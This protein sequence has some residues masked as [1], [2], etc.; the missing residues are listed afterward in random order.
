M[1]AGAWIV[2]ALIASTL[3]MAAVLLAR[4]PVRR[5]FGAQVAYALWALPALRLLL[6]P[7]P[8]GWWHAAAAAPITR[9]GETVVYLVEPFAG[10]PS[11]AGLPSASPPVGLMLG[12]AWVVG[13][14]LCLGW[15]AVRHRRFCR[16]VLA[17]ARPLAEHDGILIVASAAAP[18]PLAFGVRR[19][20]V[21]FPADFAERYDADERALALQ[22]ELGHHARRDLLANWAALAVLA[23]HWFSPLA[24]I[25]F[26]AF[27]ADQ[28]LAN[29]AGVLAHC[30]PD[31]RHA[32][33]RAIVKAASPGFAPGLSG[34][35][36]CHLHTIADLK[37]R[38][39]MLTISRTSRRRLATGSAAVTLLVAGGLGL[40]ASG[41]AAQQV[42]TTLAAP[43]PAAA[44]PETIRTVPQAPATPMPPA[45]AARPRA[46]RHVVVVRD[47]VTRTYD[48]AEADAYLAE[49]HLPVPPVPP[50]A[51][52]PGAPSAPR[53]VVMRRDGQDSDQVVWRM[54]APRVVNGRCPG[55]QAQP[56]VENRSENGRPFI[57]VCTNRIEAMER[58]ARIDVVRTEALA[59]AAA[60][61]ARTNLAL[62][63]TAI[64]R[65]RNLTPQQRTQALAGIAQAEAELRDPANN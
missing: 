54:D 13:V 15:H 42:S 18:G 28:E 27:R 56:M 61:T 7:L 38:L 1:S 36:A 62:A 25:A 49:H 29:D 58:G 17:D 26:R 16:A 57:L 50:V 47:G 60:G 64:E 46:A 3:L 23:L 4:G 8:A 40:T 48:G 34:A 31:A 9:A 41:S 44:V 19:R 6:P 65:D 43:L 63:R 2:D 10:A 45:P 12:L 33:G 30:A 20:V 51:A 35:T 21:V 52:V 14:V 11:V 59:R 5:A 55:D 37:G 53:I 22:H 24:W 39:R 32:Y